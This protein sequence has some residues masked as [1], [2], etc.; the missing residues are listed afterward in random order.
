MPINYK[1]DYNPGFKELALQL[2]KEAGWKCQICG[3]EHGK[4]HPVTKSKVVLTTM[5]L[6]QNKKNDSPENL[7]VGCQRC[8]IRYDVKYRAYN[9]IQHL[10][11]AGQTFLYFAA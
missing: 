11:K 4:P 9:R 7:R 10:R 5:H 2:K 6:D 1:R 3:A 8:H